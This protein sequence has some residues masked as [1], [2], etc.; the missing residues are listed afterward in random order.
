MAT[1]GIPET[2]ENFCSI[3]L[4]QLFPTAMKTE[5][6]EE[7][8]TLKQ[9]D[10]TV[11]QYTDKFEELSQFDE[12]ASCA[13]NGHWKRK[14][15][16]QGLREVIAQSLSSFACTS[17]VALV[18][19]AYVVEGYLKKLY[20]RKRDLGQGKKGSGSSSLHM[21]PKVNIN[22]GKRVQ[23]FEAQKFG[24]CAKCGRLQKVVSS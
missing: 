23:K 19:K 8:L 24:I 6:E 13:P 7:F 15:Y 12:L 18:K 22:K 17:Y 4:G 16:K 20:A 2:W 9:N 1:Q 3:F 14:R 5:K 10:M 11:G 21:R